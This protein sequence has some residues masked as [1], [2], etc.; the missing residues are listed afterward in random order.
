MQNKE[1]VSIKY[2]LCM[3]IAI[4]VLINIALNI[5]FINIF[6]DKYYISLKKD[7]MEKIYDNIER[8]YNNVDRLAEE[9]YKSEQAGIGV[10]I[11]DKNLNYIYKTSM[12]GK[13]MDVM[14]ENIDRDLIG[15]LGR[16]K[17]NIQILKEQNGDNYIINFAGKIGNNTA[18]LSSSVRVLEENSKIAETFVIISSVATF[19]IVLIIV[20]FFSRKITKKINEVRGITEEISNLNFENRLDINSNDEVSQ[21]LENIN[22]MSEKLENSIKQLEKTNQ[23]LKQEN[24]ELEKVEKMR[25][26]LIANISHEFKTPLTLISG[27]NQLLKNKLPSK[28]DQKYSQVIINE[29]E[30]LNQLVIDFLELSKIESSN[31]YLVKKD[32]NITE[33][34]NDILNNMQLKIKEQ[35]IKIKKDIKYKGNIYSDDKS[36]RMILSNYITNA[37][38]F[39]QNENII[40]I[41]IYEEKNKVVFSIYNTCDKLEEDTINNIWNSLY[42]TTNERNK[43]GTGLGLTIVKTIAENIKSECS[44]QNVDNGVEFKVEFPKKI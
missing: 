18:I 33:L 35:D 25:K 21:L 41:G 10:R 1:F 31:D 27:Y 30:R 38:K 28:E 24:I 5:F 9:I 29:T 20:Y 17:T 11:L 4:I 26:Q 12:F 22:N 19:G 44:V 13:D 16:S 34:T 43:S 36:V 40:K 32:I 7:S 23:D 39:V 42:K 8:E 3:L 37:L 15:S 14:K 6:M 2:K